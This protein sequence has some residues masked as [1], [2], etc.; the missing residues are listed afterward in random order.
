MDINIHNYESIIA[1]RGVRE[2]DNI[3]FERKG[4]DSFVYIVHETFLLRNNGSNDSIFEY[5]HLNKKEFCTRVYGYLCGDGVFP[6]YHRRDRY[7]MNRVV[8]ALFEEIKKKDGI[9]TEPIVQQKPRKLVK[10]EE[11]SPSSLEIEL[12]KPSIIKIIL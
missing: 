11:P 8:S 5:L 1:N 2:D 10:K 3:L 6:E 9:K 7:A 12:P 4:H